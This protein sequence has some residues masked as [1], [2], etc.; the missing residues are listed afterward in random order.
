MSDHLRLATMVVAKARGV[1]LARL[2]P[3]PPWEVAA[4]PPVLSLQELWALVAICADS[5]GRPRPAVDLGLGVEDAVR[6]QLADFGL[7]TAEEG[8]APAPAP[9]APPVRTDAEVAEVL[10]GRVVLRLPLV[11]AVTP[12]GFEAVDHDGLGSGRLDPD[13]LVAA[14]VFRTA[15]T[16]AEGAAAHRAEL[17]PRALAPE[18]FDALVADLARS[19]L[20]MAHDPDRLQSTTVRDE[21]MR[22]AIVG[23]A[24][25]R[26]HA[27]ALHAAHDEEER[28]RR[29]SSGRP[30]AMVVPVQSAGNIPPLSTG[31]VLAYARA[32]EGG[33]LADDYDLHPRWIADPADA[34]SDPTRP[35]V[36]LFT[37]YLWSHERN[38]EFAQQVK[39]TNP[40]A[41]TIHGGPDCPTYPGEDETYLRRNPQVDVVVR[42]EGEATASEVLA[43]LA[44]TIG[45]GRP[46]LSALASVPGVTYRD[47]D[48]I[49]RTADRSRIEDVDTIPSPYLTGVFDAFGETREVGLAIIETNRGCP[50][51][52]TFCDWGSATNSRIRKFDLERVLA[53]FTWCAEHEVPKIFIAD[54]NFGIFARD[55]DIA[56]HVVDLKARYGFPK[57]FI[58]NYAK[59]TVKH[60]KEIVSILAEG[61]IL[62]EGLLSL[63]S[64]DADTLLTIRRSNIKLDKY[65]A[66]SKEFRQA[67]MPLFV[68]LMMGLPGQ[69]VGSLRADL[70]QCVDR[71]V[72]AKCHATELL[73]N[74]PM[75]D[76]AYREEHRIE[77]SRPPG[78][79]G[80][81]IVEAAALGPSVV[82]STATFSREDYVEMHLMRRAYLLTENFGVL[83]QVTRFVRHETGLGEVELVERMRREATADPERWPHLA[84]VLAAVPDVMVPPVSWAYFVDEVRRYL[85]GP[86][87]L[88]ADSALEAV[89]AVQHALLPSAGRAFPA[90]VELAH[91]LPAWHAAIMAAKDQG[92]LHDWPDHVAPLRSFGPASFTVDDPRDVCGISLGFGS[93][94]D[95][96][97]DWE[98]RSPVAR[99]MP[100]HLRAT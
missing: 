11:L 89:L 63:Q 91:D 75:N 82:V 45:T 10:A 88:A 5:R 29:S 65:E 17:G 37:N 32:Y 2:R 54:A 48:R 90:T 49:V 56:R 8:P 36:Y 97:M 52:C 99:A 62:T 84:L 93:A 42:G 58:T 12:S 86:V 27:N 71:E 20:L 1:F 21:E 81:G 7:L 55:V 24:H 66:L 4:E 46:D 94:I 87:G 34:P 47:G 92:H 100:G 44:P 67:E 40:S 22:R 70:Q 14:M 43:A 79:T 76:P 18:A 68:D 64:M 51:G 25:F 30:R 77:V 6:G 16:V 78:V 39:A 38:L 72:N 53:E 15:G 9:M 57:R 59:N 85:V 33:R 13:Q 69:T 83:R 95:A 61:G 28:T 3:V 73:V 19:G 98:L 74:S 60:L 35:A 96:Y 50:Y 26:V 31:M 23:T 80:R 41:L